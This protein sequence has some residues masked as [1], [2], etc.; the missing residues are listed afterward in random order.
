MNAYELQLTNHG[1]VDANGDLWPEITG[2]DNLVV[3][4]EDYRFY[5]LPITGYPDVPHAAWA[6]RPG[7]SV[8]V[9]CETAPTGGVPKTPQ[10]ALALLVGP[11]GWPEG[12]TLVDGLPVVPR[13][14][15]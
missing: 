2:L 9:W 1:Y 13:E 7:V 12:T 3:D 4:G 8:L 5:P 10:E 14:A 6:E 15:L 11:Y